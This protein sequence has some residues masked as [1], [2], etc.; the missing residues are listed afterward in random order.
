[1]PYERPPVRIGRERYEERRAERLREEAK[2][3][4]RR[5]YVREPPDPDDFLTDGSHLAAWAREH[6][7][8]CRKAA[9][10]VLA[11]VSLD[12][13]DEAASEALSAQP[14]PG[15]ECRSLRNEALARHR[16]RRGLDLETWL[17]VTRPPRHFPDRDEQPHVV[18]ADFVWFNRSCSAEL[19]LDRL[20]VIATESEW[21]IVWP[22]DLDVFGSLTDWI[23]HVRAL[24]QH[25][26]ETK[27]VSGEAAGDEGG[28]GT[29]LSSSLEDDNKGFSRSASTISS[30]FRFGGVR[31]SVR[32]I[33]P[34]PHL[35][36][37]SDSFETVWR[38]VQWLAYNRASAFR[39]RN[40][41]LNLTIDELIHVAMIT[42]WEASKTFNGSCKFSTYARQAIT[43]AMIDYVNER[44][45]DPSITSFDGEVGG[46]V[47]TDLADRV[48][49]AVH[50]QHLLREIPDL[51]FV[52]SQ[53]WG[54]RDHELGESN[55][56]VRR[57]R[58]L[59]SVNALEMQV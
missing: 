37:P 18:A 31:P 57:H 25:P 11:L 51:R 43:F 6:L 38:E 4:G 45:R 26:R 22:N 19:L 55:V 13:V 58:A 34:W 21:P 9:R 49:E 42:V 14:P 53:D 16:E 10:R 32:T 2:P 29:T 30:R 59:K 8:C 40:R 27:Q 3:L 39:V 35:F 54:F 20:G 7:T 23:E 50:L 24:P 46:G 17:H 15:S 41:H 47:D 52:V 33:E 28:K 56:A 5:E 44:E 36:A 12:R 1:M 48:V